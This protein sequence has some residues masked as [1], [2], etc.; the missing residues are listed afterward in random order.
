[1]ESP[2]SASTAGTRTFSGGITSSNNDLYLLLYRIQDHTLTVRTGVKEKTGDGTIYLTDVLPGGRHAP[3][4]KELLP[5]HLGSNTMRLRPYRI[6]C[7]DGFGI[8][9]D[10]KD[11]SNMNEENISNALA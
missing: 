1:M 6:F 11:L 5:I 10:A 3:T 4:Y 7:F 2:T 9:S 8:P